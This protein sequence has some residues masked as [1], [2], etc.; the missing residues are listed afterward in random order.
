MI[1]TQLQACLINISFYHHND[2]KDKTTKKLVRITNNEKHTLCYIDLQNTLN[3][4]LFKATGRASLS[5]KD[6]FSKEKGRKVALKKA[7]EDLNSS[8]EAILTPEERRQI[9]EAYFA[10]KHEAPK[11]RKERVQTAVAAD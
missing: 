5:K 1:T 4:A 11:I 3:N 8:G 10:R 6:Q 2:Y 9:W 7:L